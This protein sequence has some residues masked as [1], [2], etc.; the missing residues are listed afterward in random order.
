VSW[1]YRLKLPHK[2]IILLR[3][4]D[5]PKSER[6]EFSLDIILEHQSKLKDNFSDLTKSG[7]RISR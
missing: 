2:G 7:L 1:L 4:S 3:L 6:I 5:I